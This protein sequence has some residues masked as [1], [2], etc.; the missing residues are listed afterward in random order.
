ML[1]AVDMKMV[2]ICVMF[3]AVDTGKCKKDLYF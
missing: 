2:Q 3:A 1:L